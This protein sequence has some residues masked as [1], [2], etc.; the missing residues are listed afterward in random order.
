MYDRP[1]PIFAPLDV[2]QKCLFMSKLA[3]LYPEFRSDDGS[4]NRYF[5]KVD[6]TYR[7]REDRPLL[8]VSSTSWTEDEDFSMLLKALEDYDDMSNPSLPRIMCVIT[9]KGP[10]KD[11][12]KKIVERKDWQKVKIVMPWLTSEDYSKMVGSADLGVS[13]HTS[14]SNLDLP[15]KIVDMFGCAVPALSVK[16]TT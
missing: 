9:G 13:L 3:Q 4:G 5:H 15:M 14:S 10:Q 6:G 1:P 12:Y 8:I 16:Y 2:Q 11:F 7:E